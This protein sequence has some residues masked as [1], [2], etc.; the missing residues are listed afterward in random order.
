MGAVGHLVSVMS[1]KQQ[2]A[3]LKQ[4]AHEA[5]ERADA[6]LRTKPYTP[7]TRSSDDLDGSWPADPPSIPRIPLVSA[8]PQIE[9]NRDS[10]KRHYAKVKEDVHRRTR[11]R[12]E[13]IERSNAAVY[14]QDEA[15]E[16]RIMTAVEAR[17]E[18]L[19]DEVEYSLQKIDAAL[20][21]LADGIR[22][23]QNGRGADKSRVIDL[24]ALPLRRVS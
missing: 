6:A 17:L 7:P 21:E 18:L 20:D 13:R 10:L 14:Q 1:N 5:I 4:Q 11:A 8:Q 9:W 22:E 16:A 24:P 19:Q 12:I 15:L 2:F 23:L 3:I